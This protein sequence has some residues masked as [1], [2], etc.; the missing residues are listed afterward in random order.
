MRAFTVACL[1]GVVCAA[2]ALALSGPTGPEWEQLEQAAL[3]DRQRLIQRGGCPPSPTGNATGVAWSLYAEA[4][5]RAAGLKTPAALCALVDGA[6]D[7]DRA[8]AAAQAAALA[9]ALQLLRQGARCA[10]EADQAAGVAPGGPPLE[11]LALA[12]LAV[13]LQGAIRTQLDQ[14]AWDEAAALAC[15]GI[16]AGIDLQR[17]GSLIEA[18]VGSLFVQRA[19][20][21]LDEPRLATCSDSARSLLLTML[22]RLGPLDLLDEDLHRRE[23]M[24][25][26][27]WQREPGSLGDHELQLRLRAWRNGFSPQRQARAWLHRQNRLLLPPTAVARGWSARRAQI[28][29][30][31]E[32]GEPDPSLVSHQGQPD[33]PEAFRRQGLLRIHQTQVLLAFLQRKPLPEL[34]DP[35]GDGR[36]QVEID[37]DTLTVRSATEG[38]VRRVVRKAV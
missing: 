9:P 26:V 13:A 6:A 27:L 11:I 10:V 32:L 1:F 38:F 14:G 19:L 34:D 20:A 3:A 29:Q 35:L 17:L 31:A 15:D 7:A 36:L 4:A 8:L 18:T 2:L 21:E 33:E 12:D 23:I 24:S 25:G 28:L 16:A 5:Q 30:Q 22:E 37:G